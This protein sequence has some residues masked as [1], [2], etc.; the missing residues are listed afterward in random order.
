M[1]S[2]GGTVSP[3]AEDA[4]SWA[5]HAGLLN[6]SGGALRPGGTASRCEVAVLMQRM[7]GLLCQGI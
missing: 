7:A 3:W 2:D 5:V 1:Y 6:G 4:V